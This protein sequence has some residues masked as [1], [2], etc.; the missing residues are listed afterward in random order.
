MSIPCRVVRA[1]GWLGNARAVNKL[2][3]LGQKREWNRCEGEKGKDTT[4]NNVKF[5]FGTPPR[6]HR[7]RAVD[8]VSP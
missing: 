5:H 2:T 1:R 3:V 4:L 7:R 8:S 6:R